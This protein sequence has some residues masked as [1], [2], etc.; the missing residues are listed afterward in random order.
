MFSQR[1]RIEG[2]VRAGDGDH[3]NR[4]QDAHGVALLAEPHRICQ[5]SG[6]GPVGPIY[7][8]TPLT[9]SVYGQLPIEYN[10][11]SVMRCDQQE[12]IL[13]LA[14]G[15]MSGPSGKLSPIT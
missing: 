14:D 15:P 10:A 5:W 2:L 7:R 4:E 8:L 6:F 3:G 1:V 9:G 12:P 13:Q 11:L